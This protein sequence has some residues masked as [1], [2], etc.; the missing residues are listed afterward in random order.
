MSMSS[1]KK[2]PP[3][4]PGGNFGSSFSAVAKQVL[5]NTNFGSSLDNSS[6]RKSEVIVNEKGV[7]ITQN[8]NAAALISESV[9]KRRAQQNQTPNHNDF[10]HLTNDSSTG[11][12]RQK[13]SA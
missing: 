7:P 8:Y 1:S 2:K 5:Q 11:Y 6:N 10:G 13:S 4:N 12:L 9:M 3:M